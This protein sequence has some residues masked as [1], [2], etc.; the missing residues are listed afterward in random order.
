MG[1]VQL[2]A[3]R[4]ELWRLDRYRELK[5]LLAA[6]AIRNLRWHVHYDLIVN[7]VKVGWYTADFV[8]YDVEKNAEIVED[9]KGTHTRDWPLRRNLFDA[10]HPDT[11]IVE[12]Y[13]AGSPKRRAKRRR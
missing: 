9:T 3:G 7:G 10:L 2:T 6:R 8:Y 12:V 1:T 13:K 11:P 4:G 5:L